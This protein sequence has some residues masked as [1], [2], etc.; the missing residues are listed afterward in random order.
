[1][2]RDY[3]IHIDYTI[4]HVYPVVKMQ[5]CWL[6]N[7]YCCVL[8]VKITFWALAYILSSDSI[9]QR[10]KM[11]IDDVVGVDSKSRFC[12]VVIYYTKFVLDSLLFI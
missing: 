8:C 10:V 11:E 3:T 4:M 7:Y 5:I 2:D 12:T 9:L 1:M 6:T